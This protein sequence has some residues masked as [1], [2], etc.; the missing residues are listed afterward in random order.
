[1]DLTSFCLAFIFS[2]IV[3]VTRLPHRVVGDIRIYIALPSARHIGKN[4]INVSCYY[5][6]SVFGA[7]NSSQFYNVPKSENKWC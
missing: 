7:M 2:T 1:M 6:P 4:S 5:H 3:L